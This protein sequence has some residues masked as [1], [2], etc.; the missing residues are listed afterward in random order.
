MKNKVLII[1]DEI[2][3][4]VGLH[5]LLD[6]NALGFTL[7]DDAKDGQEAIRSIEN[8]HPDILLL[9]LNIPK[10]NGLQILEYLRE[11]HLDCKVIVISCNEEFEMVKEAMKLGAYDYLRKLNLSSESLQEILQK[12]RAE[13]HPSFRVREI[14]YEEIISHTGKD[15][16]QDVGTYRTLLC[17][18]PHKE[19]QEGIFSVMEQCRAWFQKR[20]QE[21]LQIHKG[22]QC[23][24]FLFDRRFSGEFYK[25]LYERLAQRCSVKLYLGICEEVMKEETDINRAIALAEQIHMVSYYDEEQRI[26]YFTERIPAGEHSPKGMTHMQAALKKAVGEFAKEDT[27]KSIAHIFAA[28]RDERY[29]SIN[30]LRRIFMDMLGVFS[31][32]AQSLNGAIEEIEV[33]GDNCHYQ[34]LMMSSSLSEIEEWFLE[35][36]DA[37]YERFLID[38]KCSRSE[39]LNSAF[40]YIDTHLKTQIHQ[41]DAAREIGVSSAYLSTVFKKEMGQ[42][43]IDYVNMRKVG[44][45]KEMLEE[46]LLVYEVSEILGF[47]N[48]TYFSKV[49][50]KYTEISPDT[51]RRERVNRK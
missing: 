18:L 17:I 32:T 8:E 16:F 39:I 38:Y 5:Q 28:V 36:T 2:L 30:V 49:F 31:M 12:C 21:F 44:L 35:F 3:A 34:S 15:I 14:R 37:F 26:H 7:L 41:A 24:Y 29:T 23:C 45:A 10:I 51:F 6:W 20:G 46:G 11:N 19:K 22:V 40:H 50:K 4:R 1:E 27:K 48:C 33:R 43:F 47:E 9:D 25:E 42:N 13:K